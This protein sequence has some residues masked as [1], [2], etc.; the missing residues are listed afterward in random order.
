MPGTLTVLGTATTLLSYGGITVLTDPNFLH[1]GQRA[2]LGKGLWSRR[3][4]EPAMQPADLPPLDAVVLSHLHG[5][6]FDR[7]ARRELPKDLPLLTTPAAARRLRRQGF[8]RAAGLQTWQSQEVSR[9]GARLRVT[10]VPGRHA[11]GLLQAALPPVMGS[12][13]EFSAPGEPDLSVYITGDTLL[14]DALREVP[15]RHPDLDLGLFHLGGTRIPF[16]K[17]LLVTMD[18][19][20]GADLLEIV[21]PVRT[22]PVHH[23]DYGVFASPRSEFLAEVQRR[24]L[25]GVRPVDLG[26]TVPLPLP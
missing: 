22:V 21:R 23:D 26:Q 3:L 11:R 24:G 5:D 13:L 10:A 17:G 18:G 1:R 4:T 12:V 15:R 9:G 2:Y 25:P 19:R 20:M 6:H 8:A 14:L 16:G 7:I